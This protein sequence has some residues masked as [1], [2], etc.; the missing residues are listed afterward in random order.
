MKAPLALVLALFVASCAQIPLEKPEVIDVNT[1]LSGRAIL[2][3][4]VLPG[5]LP[6]ED[7]LGLDAD[8]LAYLGSTAP[9]ESPS[10]RLQSLVNA[11]GRGDFHIEYDPNSTLPA[12]KTY[13]LQRGNCLAFTLMMVAMARELGVEAY[14]NEVDVPP[15]WGQ[16]DPETFT[17]Y[18]HVNMV[19]EYKN[20]RRVIDFNLEAYDPAYRQ[21]ALDDTTAFALY[22]SNRGIEL[23]R[24]GEEK[25][26][27]LY[28]RKALQLRPQRSDIWSNLGA[29]Y[30]RFNHLYAAEQSYLKALQI[31]R[32]NLVAISNLERLYRVSGREELADW[33][34]E[35]VRF[36]RARNP[37]YLHHQ[38]LEAYSAGD[39]KKA[40]KLLRRALRANDSDHRFHFLLG[41]TRYRLG[42]LIASKASFKQA[43]S[44]VSSSQTRGVYKQKLDLLI[45]G[46]E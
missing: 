36:H 33:Y 14:F 21:Y 16:D 5:E 11:Y 43:F 35:R 27:F 3:R 17:V 9:G 25:F 22:Y 31:E 28:L 23:M 45:N 2:D 37:Y 6:D 4:P 15:V 24:S 13:Q 38:A 39:Y 41:L 34:A 44:Q 20:R 18:R 40:E 7:L 32:D 19:A 30:S 1:A 8:I 10:K 46:P 42:D 26:A 12:S 29:V